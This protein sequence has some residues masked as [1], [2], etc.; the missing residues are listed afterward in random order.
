MSDKK[1]ANLLGIIDRMARNDLR[2]LV[3]KKVIKRVGTSD[4][5]SYYILAEI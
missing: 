2:K 1:Y 3:N 5:T 4:K